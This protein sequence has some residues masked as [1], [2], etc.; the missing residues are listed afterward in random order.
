MKRASNEVRALAHRAAD[1]AAE[2]PLDGLDAAT[3][4][5]AAAIH[6]AFGAQMSSYDIADWL[7]RLA[8]ELETE[9]HTTPGTRQR[10]S[11]RSPND[12]KPD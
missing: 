4:A 6:V 5:M 9:R 2:S 1:L 11:R 3:A 10:Q 7:R 8:A 12:G